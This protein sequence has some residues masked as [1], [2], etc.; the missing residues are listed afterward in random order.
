MLRLTT[1]KSGREPEAYYEFEKGFRECHIGGVSRVGLS[2]FE[3]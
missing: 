2:R 3:I 1:G